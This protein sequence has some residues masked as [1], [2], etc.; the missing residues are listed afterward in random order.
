MNCK[1]TLQATSR[2][3]YM[4]LNSHSNSAFFI[5]MS[6]GV[7]IADVVLNMLHLLKRIPLYISYVTRLNYRV[8][9]SKFRAAV[10]FNAR[11]AYAFTPV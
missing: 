7:P 11:W 8:G 9:G 4:C 1:K 10:H 6:D 3:T 2:P 5:V